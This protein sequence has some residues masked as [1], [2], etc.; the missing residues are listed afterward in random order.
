[1]KRYLALSFALIALLI[2]APQGCGQPTK[3]PVK[4]GG[5]GTAEAV[6]RKVSDTTVA[7]VDQQSIG[8]VTVEIKDFNEIEELIASKRGK[9][10][11]VDCWSTWCDPCVKEFPGLVELHN[12]FKPTDLACVS[13]SFNYEGGR[14]EKPADHVEPVL[15][16]LRGQKAT[17]DNVIA[18]VPSEELYQKL[19]FKSA[20]VPAIFVYDRDG[21]IA[22]QFESEEAKYSEVG[23]LV[24]ELIEKS[25][26]ASQRGAD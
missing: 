17:F 3:T 22:K 4:A 23:R 10:V 20:A 9:V 21:T 8:D 6:K 11:V 7:V 19:G 26:A 25:P 5:S 1:M 12:K 18:S 15:E 16:F 2:A 13:L 14:K 24:A